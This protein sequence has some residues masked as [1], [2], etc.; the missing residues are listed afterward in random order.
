M[1]QIL[2]L[3][4]YGYRDYISTIKNSFESN[5]CNIIDIPYRKLCD[6]DKLNNTK[7]MDIIIQSVNKSYDDDNPIKLIFM[8]MLPND[9]LFI[10]TIKDN[11]NNEITKIVFYNF[12]DPD[13]FN[14]DLIKY[15]N[16]VDYFITPNQ[17][18][19]NRL[20]TI[21]RN[22]VIC[23]PKYQLYDSNN[24]NKKEVPIENI[25][26]ILYDSE[27]SKYYD[28]ADIVKNI[29]LISFDYDLD[30]R[31][32]GDPST[33]YVFPDIYEG[34]YNRDN[35][36]E[37]T[38]SSKIVI[39]LKNMYAN[40]KMDSIITDIMY[41]KNILLIPQSPNYVSMLKHNYNCYIYDEDTYTNIILNAVINYEKV[42]SI[43]NNAHNYVMK[44][45]SLSTWT[46]N[47]LR[48][49]IDDK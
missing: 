34:V 38:K 20:K 35:I 28:G 17:I 19:F 48:H 10:P 7:I 31:L 18:T 29:K 33:E 9:A 14:A 27:F 30:I 41:H 22:N 15:S 37:I 47:I 26:C 49:C 4:F 2:F 44:Y 36:Y 45:L 13:S 42:K 32:Y 6:D 40:T 12:D 16:D 24:N 5:D 46:D 23:L 11:I 25:I 39:Y 8:F 3:T 1:H 43:G 21:C